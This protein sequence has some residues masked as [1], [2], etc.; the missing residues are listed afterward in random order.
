MDKESR[1]GLTALMWGLRLLLLAALL[2]ASALTAPIRAGSEQ[3]GLSTG[4]QNLAG[5][6][7]AS[8]TDSASHERCADPLH[9][10]C[11]PIGEDAD[12]VAARS[13]FVAS[14][15]TGDPDAPYSRRDHDLP[16]GQRTLAFSARAPPSFS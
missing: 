6:C 5:D 9:D 8:Q 10:C 11:L 1:T 7:S 4:E 13:A 12:G 16:R 15:R 14:L 3:L 2:P